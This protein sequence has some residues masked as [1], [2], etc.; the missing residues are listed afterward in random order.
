LTTADLFNLA[1]FGALL[2][3]LAFACVWGGRLER[4]GA[5]VV[6]INVVIALVARQLLGADGPVWVFCAIDLL[7]AV[8]FAG[9]ALRNPERLWPG[10]A[11][12]AM[13]FVM[14]FSAT[15][16]IGFPLSE[17]AYA[18]ALN[19]PGLLVQGALVSGTWSALRL[20]RAE[21]PVGEPQPA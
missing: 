13:T 9:L 3:T 21:H 2:C 15:R 12:V 7:T 8:V 17:L 1:I 20:R 10:V 19:L 14:V 16:A 18:V 11:G 4:T 6:F 5:G